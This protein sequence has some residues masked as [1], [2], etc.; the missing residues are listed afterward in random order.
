MTTQGPFIP[1]ADRSAR[2]RCCCGAAGAFSLVEMTLVIATIAVLAAI[3]IPRYADAINRYRV[4]MAAKRIVADLALA[5]SSARASGA[6]QVVDFATPA[7][8]YTMAGLAA[9]DGRAGSYV[10]RLGDDP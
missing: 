3:G 9:P 8:G 1:T 10:V 4:D 5:R 7:N 2:R 6:G